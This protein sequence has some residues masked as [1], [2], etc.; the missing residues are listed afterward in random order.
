MGQDSITLRPQ[1]GDPEKVELCLSTPNGGGRWPAILFVHGHQIE[2]RSGARIF[3]DVGRLARMAD[4]GFVAAAVSMPGYG[5]TT[6]PPD[7][8]GP[9]TQAAIESAHTTRQ[10]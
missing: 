2:E 10:N 1:S 3:A 9:R 5:E 4:R 7:Y 6:G 8:C